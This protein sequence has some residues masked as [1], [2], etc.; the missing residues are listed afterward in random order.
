LDALL[1]TVAVPEMVPALVG[2]N[3]KLNV[4]DCPAASVSGRVKPVGENPAPVAL[5]LETDTLALPVFVRV[6]V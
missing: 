3:T 2:A 1:D 4:V 6:T 5:M